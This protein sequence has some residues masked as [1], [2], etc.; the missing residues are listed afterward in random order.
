MLW[1]LSSQD[2]TWKMLPC[3]VYTQSMT[4]FVDF[5]FPMI[6]HEKYYAHYQHVHNI[7]RVIL[8]TAG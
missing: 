2:I 1:L 6:S 3:A 8:D 5:C 7:D 4:L